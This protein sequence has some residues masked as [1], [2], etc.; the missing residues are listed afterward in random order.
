MTQVIAD[1]GLK[2][3]AYMLELAKAEGIPWDSHH[4]VKEPS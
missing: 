3:E 2:V 1:L 4:C